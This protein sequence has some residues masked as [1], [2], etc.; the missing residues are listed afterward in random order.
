MANSSKPPSRGRWIRLG[1]LTATTVGAS[2]RYLGDKLLDGLRGETGRNAARSARLQQAGETLAGTLGDMKGAAMKL[3]QF[4]S[5]DAALLPDEIRKALEV[6]QKGATPMQPD[7]VRRLLEARLGQPTEALFASFDEQPV[8]AASLGQVHRATLL[9][10]S[11][12]AVKLQYPDMVQRL[13]DDLANLRLM[14]RLAPVSA[15]RDRQEEYID[16][17]RSAFLAEA[18]YHQ[19]AD[20]LDEAV[21]HCAAMPNIAVPRPVRSHSCSTVLTMSYLEG[22][23]LVE[24]LRALPAA[25]RNALGGAL[26]LFYAQLFHRQQW[27]HGDVHPGNFLLLDD[28]RIGVLDFGCVCRFEADLTDGFLHLLRAIWEDRPD[29]VPGLYA[30]MGFSSGTVDV[31]AQTLE[32]FHRMV[33]APFYATEPFD[34]GAWELRSALR[35]FV[36]EH[37]DFL[38]LTP[39]P[40]ALL[41]LRVLSGLGGMLHEVGAVVDIRGPAEAL[42]EERLGP[43]SGVGST[44]Q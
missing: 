32:I 31:S 30:S 22:V 10:G 11:P 24:G 15:L 35:G 40:E 43:P 41:Y 44:Q 17:L 33:M 2:S 1:K 12:V 7:Q 20:N 19:E 14:L 6:L 29:D 23:P 16:Q 34:W 38:R 26:L 28:D 25:R 3:G 18:D 42:A 39:P 4:L 9:D 5:A 36:F 27:L 8:G 37:V 13:E 21:R